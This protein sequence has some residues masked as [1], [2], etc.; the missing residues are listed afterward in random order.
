[1]FHSC[2]DISL[3]LQPENAKLYSEDSKEVRFELEVENTNVPLLSYFSEKKKKDLFLKSYQY[4]VVLFKVDT[5]E[6]K[7]K[8][9]LYLFSIIYSLMLSLLPLFLFL[10]F[11]QRKLHVPLYTPLTYQYSLS[12]LNTIKY[13]YIILFFHLVYGTVQNIF[14]PTL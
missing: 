12:I 8:I 5:H 3:L 6:E 14:C 13:V 11:L 9:S 10:T 7:K 2:P 1:M 4:I